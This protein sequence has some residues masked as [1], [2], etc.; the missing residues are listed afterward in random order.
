MDQRQTVFALQTA[1]LTASGPLTLAVDAVLADLPAQASFVFDPGPNPQPGQTWQT[2]IDV[3]LPGTPGEQRLHVRSVEAD[4]SG[5]SFDMTSDTGI[6][7][8]GLSDPDHPVV[9]GGGGE[10]IG[11]G[12]FWSRFDYAGGLPTDPITVQIGAIGLRVEQPLQVQWAPPAGSVVTPT[13]SAVQPGDQ[14]TA[15]LT[16][17]GWKAALAASAAQ[18]PSLPAGLPGKVLLFS[19]PDANS[20][21][22]EY[23]VVLSSLAAGSTGAV[24]RQVFPQ[25]HTGALSPDG[26]QLAYSNVDTGLSILDLASGQVTPLPGTTHGD[27]S[28]VWSPDGRQIV[29]NR[30]MGIFDLFII[31]RDGSG[32]RQLSQEAGQEWPVGWLDGGNRLLYS[33]PGR[34]NV[35]LISQVD[36]A[37]GAVQPFP[38]DNVAAVSPDGRRLLL[39]ERTFGDRWLASLSDLDGANRKPLAGADLWFLSPQFSPDGQWL[40]ASVSVGSVEDT[41]GA[42]LNVGTCQVIAL[43]GL[44][45]SFLS[46]TP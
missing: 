35:D 38:V 18:P 36:L 32:L 13:Q 24:A 23:Q 30:G 2:D 15:C 10:G 41:V 39:M 22:G 27:S 7:T 43:P 34:E 8:A 16:A 46:W 31:N 12:N 28:P 42:L 4:V 19:P 20:P 11:P 6:L 29:F 9:A 26:T 44:K 25:A 40:L 21:S 14:S 37:S 45:G 33:L 3:T 17:A 5:Y 1:P